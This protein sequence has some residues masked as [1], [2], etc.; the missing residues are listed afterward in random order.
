[1]RRVLHI[2]EEC[3]GHCDAMST[4]LAD[5]GA[6]VVAHP[7][8]FRALACLHRGEGAP[9]GAV[10]VCVD[11]LAA[12]EFEFFELVGRACDDVAVLA[13]SAGGRGGRVRRAISLGASGAV[14][15]DR[16]SVAAV[17]GE[18]AEDVVTESQDCDV[19]SSRT[20][21]EG[22]FDTE[23]VPVEPASGPLLSEEEI[24]ML[25]NGGGEAEAVVRRK[26]IM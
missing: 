16:A 21:V 2:V 9:F 15:V 22:D 5:L 8:V 4:V 17:L 23:P 14:V 6:D 12:R 13:Y 20:F 25:L 24:R 18:R 3:G 1:M 19:A 10:L 7:D 26:D 11:Y